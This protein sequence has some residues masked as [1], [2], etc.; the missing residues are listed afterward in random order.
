MTDKLRKYVLPNIPFVFIGWAFLKLGTAYRLAAG[1]DFAHKFIGLGQTVGAAFADFAPGLAPFDWLVGI[2]GAVAF[3]L[4]ICFKSKN[5]KKFRRDEEY[6]SARWGSE[7][8]IRPFVDPKFEN[9][10]ILTATEQLTMN[11]R[12]KNPANARNLNFCGIGSSGSGK[13]RFWLTPQLLQAHSS[14][15]V[16]DPK[17]GVLGQVGSFLQKRGYKIKVFN[18]IDFSKSMHYNPLAYIKTEADILKFVN[19]LI[20]NTK[21]EGKEGDPFWTKAETLLYCALIAYIIFEGPAEDR[22]MNTLVDM[23]SGMEVKEDDENYKNAVDYMFDGLAKRKPDCFAVKQYRK[24]KLSSGKTAKSILIS[25][26]ARLAPFDIPQL[27]EIMSYDELELDRMGD[28]RTATFF[29]ISDTDS[30]YNFLVALA[31]SQMFNLLCERADNVHGGRLPHHVRVLWDEAANTGQ[32][33]QLEKLVAVIRSREISL[34]LLYAGSLRIL[35]LDEEVIFMR[36]NEDMSRVES[37]AGI[38]ATL[39]HHPD[40]SFYSEQLLP[41]HFTNKENR[42]IYQALRSLAQSGVQTIDPY[43]IVQELQSK[44]ATRRFADD[45]SVDQLYTLIENSDIL[46]RDSVEAYMVLVNN[47]LDAAFRRDTYQQLKECQRLCLQPTEANIEQKI[48]KMLDDV[49]MEFSATNDVPPYKDVVDKYWNEI[50]SRQS[51]GYSGIPFKFPALNDYATIERGELFI[52]G[53]EQKQGKSMMLLNC[54]VD[55]LR[56]GYAVL[57]LD[58]ELNTRLFTAR[59]LAHLSGIEYKRLTAGTYSAEEAKRIDEAREWIK[60]RRFTHI[61]IPT[62]D[63]QSIYTTVNKVRHTQGLDVLIVDYFKSTGEGDAFNS[64]QELG[65][66]VDTVKNRICGDMNIAGIGA[67]QATSTGRLADSAKIARNASTI[68]MITDKTPEEIEADGAECG[69]K[70]LRVVVNRNGMQMAQDEYISLFFD[71]NHILYEQ[72]KQAIPRLPF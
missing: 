30:T 56:Q 22:N 45:L 18:S 13:T 49:M 20:S 46:C 63:I 65:R 8:D 72:A 58:S 19:A 11:T 9:N 70:K 55:L 40:F 57:Y 15:V 41:N 36:A 61:Y 47:V 32:V 37:E 17:G 27:R 31:F 4:L 59:L 26:G 67:A 33:P 3:R 71:G 68:A 29:C 28:R 14:Y 52:F 54:A 23:I 66:F 42:I 51:A 5:A 16:V 34:C 7:K 43:I 44:E 69:N 50:Q 38:I 10:M 24:F 12:P 64:Y 53:A 2:V 62:F 39:I 6:G 25:C 35:R 48:Y 1:S 21:G 60:T